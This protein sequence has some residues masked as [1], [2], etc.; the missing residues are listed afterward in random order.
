MGFHINDVQAGM[1]GVIGDVHPAWVKILD[2]QGDFVRQ[3]QELSPETKWVGRMWVDNYPHYI[4]GKE[5]G[6]EEFFRKLQSRGTWNLIDIWEGINEPGP[7]PTHDLMRFQVRLAQLLHDAGKQY[8]YGSWSVGCPAIPDWK[9]EWIRQPLRLADYVSVHEYA[10][11][12][13]DDPRGLDG[14][15]GTGWFTLRYRK[16]WSDLPADCQKPILITECGIDSGAAHWDPHGQ[17][18]WKSFTDIAGYIEQLRWYEDNLDACVVG[19]LPYCWGVHDPTWKT[20]DLWEPA[21]ARQAFSD[22]IKSRRPVMPVGVDWID[23]RETLPRHPQKRYASRPIDG[24][25][26]V[27]IHHSAVAASVQPEAIARY[28]VYR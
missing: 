17:G 24:I 18:G 1:L 25:D 11:P 10:S 5:A 20:F 7:H 15:T 16:W 9:S 23:V 4:N 6:A 12:R 8:A 27:V 28:H 19:A 13:M 14:D 22:Y 26:T 3:A 21:E 2:H